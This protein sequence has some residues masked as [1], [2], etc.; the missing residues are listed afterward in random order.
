MVASL[1]LTARNYTTG[2]WIAVALDGPTI[3]EVREAEGATEFDESDP[4]IAPAFWD[5][6]TNGRWGVSFANGA[7]TIEQV[8]RIVRAQ[9]EMG[10]AR[11]CPTLITAG[12]EAL[13]HGLSTIASACDADPEIDRRVLGIHL[14]GPWISPEDGFRGAH[15]REHVREPDWEE[16][17]ALQRSSGS[18]I[19][20]VTLAPERPGAIEMIER[21]NSAG[22]VAAVGHSAADAETIARG[23]W[24]GLKTSTHLGNGVPAILP[25]H[26]NPIWAQAA[27]DGLMASFIADG[28]HLDPSTLAVLIRAKTPRRTILV[29]DAS[30]LADAP[31]GRYGPWDVQEDRS[32]V[33]AGTPYLA[34]SNLDLWKAVRMAVEIGAM[35]VEEAIDSASLRPAALL[36]WPRP[37]LVVGQPADFILFRRAEDDLGFDLTATCVGGEWVIRADEA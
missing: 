3:A 21:L 28:K 13:I 18:R 25:R 29:S 22:V 34:G 5:I 23:V 12:H 36:N 37:S 10:T 15:D 8:G 16:F 26:P 20:M 31:P 24:A 27:N 32:I 33:V 6:Q 2:R 1:T 9:A 4:W 35:T 7:L 17:E 14:E 30:P 11:L 19:V